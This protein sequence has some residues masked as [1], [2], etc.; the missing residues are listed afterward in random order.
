MAEERRADRSRAGLLR[1]DE[2]DAIRATLDLVDRLGAAH[3]FDPAK[4]VNQ[5]THEPF[6]PFIT[7]MRGAMR[8]FEASRLDRRPSREG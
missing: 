7:R 3:G 4:L 1:G 8:S 6:G 5:R 2:Y